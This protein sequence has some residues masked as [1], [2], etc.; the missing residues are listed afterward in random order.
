M[1][2][3]F[4]VVWNGRR[5]GVYA[6]WESCRVQVDGFSGATF[7]KFPSPEAAARAWQDGPGS[8]AEPVARPE[9]FLPGSIAVDAACAGNPGPMEYRGVDLATGEEIFRV[10]PMHGTNNLGEFLA[11]VHGLSWQHARE[12]RA[13][14]WSDSRTALSWVRERR[15]G[16]TLPR[17]GDSVRAWALADR[18]LRWLSA[19]PGHVAPHKWPT[20]TWGEIPADFGRK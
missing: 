18:A 14:V 5:P 16:C 7:K 6:S 3:A 4:Y 11:V 19:H 9:A 20:A 12:S 13:P 15:V 1:T 10:G 8:I 2:E 17:E